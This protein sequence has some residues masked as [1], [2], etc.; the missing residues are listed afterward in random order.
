M[1]I[2]GL[3]LV[4]KYQD[5]FLAK[6]DLEVCAEILDIVLFYK[7]PHV[8][9]DGSNL[10]LQRYYVRLIINILKDQKDVEVFVCSGRRQKELP[11]YF[12][13]V[14]EGIQLE[15]ASRSERDKLR[16]IAFM[17]GSK[18]KQDD[19]KLIN[20]IQRGFPG[21]GLGYIT[22]ADAEM[23]VDLQAKYF[24]LKQ[25]VQQE[26]IQS[27]VNNSHSTARRRRLVKILT[28]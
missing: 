14:L 3:E 23:A 1:K 20:E 12:S 4:E 18:I 22:I 13:N 15:A 7:N 11:Q 16:V 21:L 19:E 17:E 24:T 10:L 26:R 25:G 28:R 9:L 6:A 5:E 8:V 2:R 27:L